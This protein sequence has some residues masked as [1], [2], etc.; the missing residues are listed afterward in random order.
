MFCDASLTG[1]GAVVR[2]AKTRVHWTHDELDH[3]NSLELKAILLGLQ[4]L[5]KDSRDTLII[6]LQLPV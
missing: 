6:P 5:Y 3:I 1:W 4:S 2:D